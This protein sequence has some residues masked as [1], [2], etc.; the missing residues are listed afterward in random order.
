MHFAPF[1]DLSYLI[2][3]PVDCVFWVPNVAFS[4]VLFPL[5][6]R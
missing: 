1:G 2:G 5:S 4:V 3:P 6:R